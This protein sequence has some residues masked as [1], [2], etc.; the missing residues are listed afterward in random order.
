GQHQEF[1]AQFRRGQLA[2]HPGQQFA[3]WS[4]RGRQIADQELSAGAATIGQG[5]L[6]GKVGEASQLSREQSLN[7]GNGSLGKGAAAEAT[8]GGHTGIGVAGGVIES[9][10]QGG[11]CFRGAGA[12]QGDQG[13]APVPALEVP[14]LVNSFVQQAAGTQAVQELRELL[15][16]GSLDAIQKNRFHDSGS[17]GIGAPLLGRKG[18]AD[19]A[20]PLGA[21]LQG[22][23]VQALEVAAPVPAP[24]DDKSDEQS[25]GDGRG[26]NSL[27]HELGGERFK[28]GS[29]N[30]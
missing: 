19:D 2:Q 14:G 6:D 21:D 23:A 28:N 3:G 22:R 20:R 11:N 15:R 24:E 25:D 16:P 10:S 30:S 27:E 17:E 1:V 13:H 29:H 26:E 9:F 12:A 5:I 8:D 7:N 4:G 18:A